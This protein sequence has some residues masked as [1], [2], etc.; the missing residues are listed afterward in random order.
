M[1]DALHCAESVPCWRTAL[2]W[3]GLWQ[4]GKA[5]KSRP[6]RFTTWWTTMST[7]MLSCHC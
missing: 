4:C 1:R 2:H 3:G 7:S 6:C 5:F